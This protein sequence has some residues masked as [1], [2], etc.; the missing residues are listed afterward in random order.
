MPSVPVEQSIPAP[1]VDRQL[2]D[3]NTR[4]PEGQIKPITTNIEE[5]E[6]GAVLF[7][8]TLPPPGRFRSAERLLGG[9]LKTNDGSFGNH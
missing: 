4:S 3:L 5:E 1:N 8:V 2:S 9:G 7:A 6:C